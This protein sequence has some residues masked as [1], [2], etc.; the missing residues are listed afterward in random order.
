MAQTIEALERKIK[1][2]NGVIKSLTETIGGA[3][4]AVSELKDLLKEEEEER[5]L[6]EKKIKAIK[7]NW[8]DDRGMKADLEMFANFNDNR[9]MVVESGALGKGNCGDQIDALLSPFSSTVQNSD[10]LVGGICYRGARG[11]SNWAFQWRPAQVESHTLSE[12]FDSHGGR[13]LV[14]MTRKS[15]S[16]SLISAKDFEESVNNT[17]A[18][19]IG[20]FKSLP[21]DCCLDMLNQIATALEQAKIY[22]TFMIVKREPGGFENFGYNLLGTKY[23]A[24]KW[25]KASDGL[26]SSTSFC[27]GARM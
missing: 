1:A 10:F 20:G 17:A 16:F 21:D 25:H 18:R 22:P 5:V 23:S 15:P 6:L 12:L 11:Y 19:V 27:V 13:H 2:K 4:T 24:H 14:F 3:H 7:A 8:S 26:F 9:K